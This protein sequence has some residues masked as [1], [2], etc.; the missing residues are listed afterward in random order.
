[1]QWVLLF[2]REN[3]MQKFVITTSH[4]SGIAHIVTYASSAESAVE[5]VKNAERCP[6]A[7]IKSVYQIN[8][9][10]FL[11]RATGPDAGQFLRIKPAADDVRQTPTPRNPYALGY[12][13]RIPTSHMVKNNRGRWQRVYVRQ[14]S[15]AGTAWVKHL[16]G[17]RAIIE[18]EGV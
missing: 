6:D 8:E 15:N 2:N 11:V 12:G 13:E 7:S 1:M 17:F 9:C 3:T 14:F 18:I 16:T 4:D 5:I 10:G